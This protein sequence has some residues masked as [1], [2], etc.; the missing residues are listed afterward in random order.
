MTSKKV[1][2]RKETF[3]EKLLKEGKRYFFTM[4]E[5][6]ACLK[7][8]SCEYKKMLFVIDRYSRYKT[9]L[10]ENMEDLIVYDSDI[11]DD[12]DEDIEDA[13]EMEYMDIEMEGYENEENFVLFEEYFHSFDSIAYQRNILANMEMLILRML[14][15]DGSLINIEFSV[16]SKLKILLKNYYQRVEKFLERNKMLVEFQD[17]S[18]K[19]QL[20]KSFEKK[21]N[22]LQQLL[23]KISEKEIFLV[24]IMVQP[25]M[26]K[27]NGESKNN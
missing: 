12:N 14:I 4:E 9:Q 23:L 6:H 15:L 22:Q 5:L 3:L 19:K 20:T 8:H 2:I 18:E 1:L 10:K 16:Y 17:N 26:V 25:C 27:N 13:D 24:E 11:L 7:K 21:Y